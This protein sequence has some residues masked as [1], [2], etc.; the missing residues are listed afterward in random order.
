MRRVATVIVNWN[1]KNDTLSCLASLR[2]LK[3]HD[4]TNEIIVVDNGSTDGSAERIQKKFSNVHLIKNADNLG[5]AGGCNMGV[6]YALNIGVEHI[7][8]LNNDTI[9][10]PHALVG[11][12]NV[13]RE[14]QKGIAGSKIYFA[15]G[16]EY[17]ND[18]YKE[19]E[20]GRIIWFA[21]GSIDWGNMYASHRGID[22]VDR[23]QY[24]TPQET[25][26]ITGCSMMVD[27]VVFETIG[28]FDERYFLYLEDLDFCL[29]AKRAG[30]SLWYA[31]LSVLWH[32]NAGSTGKPGHA[33]HDYYFTRNRLLIGFS[34]APIRTRIA[35]GREAMRFI[36]FGS[37]VKRK[38]VL[39]FAFRKFGNQ[40][41]WKT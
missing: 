30:F 40:Y 8:F 3:L 37:S 34:Y 35:L 39:D 9:V 28:L 12:L 24:D 25:Q 31:P 29:R 18:K 6:R 10:D 15:P 22:E 27:R 11:L 32:M 2:A 36:I 13:L 1:G 23:K 14:G 16:R 33:L 7:W 21:G 4:I 19:S 5:F 17:H 38:A 20:R 26:Y 41:T